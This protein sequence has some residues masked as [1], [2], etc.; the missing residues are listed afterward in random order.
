MNAAF[1]IGQFE[2]EIVCSVLGFA[3][4]FLI[5]QLLT[6]NVLS[7]FDYLLH[8]MP[9]N[10]FSEH[11]CE[12]NE[13]ILAVFKT[14]NSGSLLLVKPLQFIGRLHGSELT[15]QPSSLIYQAIW[16]QLNS[17]RQL[18]ECVTMD[19]FGIIIQMGYERE[20]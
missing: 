19:V 5:V 20:S 12:I 16:D 18:G 6:I 11:L 8:R 4:F 17:N 15:T 10:L 1:L 7:D 3:W 2:G 14:L 13:Y 9:C